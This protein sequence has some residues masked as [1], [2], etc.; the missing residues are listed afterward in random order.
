MN[1]FIGTGNLGSLTAELI[2]EVG[3]TVFN[4]SVFHAL[5]LKYL[6]GDSE[7]I[8]TYDYSDET[9]TVP[10]PLPATSWLLLT[11]FL[12]IRATR[13]SSAKLN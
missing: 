4:F 1:P 13:R 10:V 11:G 5:D 12:G 3:V 6:L 7:F 9:T 8:V 2:S